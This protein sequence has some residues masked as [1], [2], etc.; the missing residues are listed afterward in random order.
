MGK[1]R[2]NTL[3]QVGLFR[4]LIARATPLSIGSATLGERLET[5]LYSFLRYPNVSKTTIDLE[6][7]SSL[8]LDGFMGRYREITRELM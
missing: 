1:V 4:Y 5:A 2:K 7:F 8:T 6:A 3:D